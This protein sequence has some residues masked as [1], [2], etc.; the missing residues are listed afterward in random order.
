[1]TEPD[2]SQVTAARAGNALWPGLCAF[3]GVTFL[4]YLGVEALS[5]VV[6]VNVALFGQLAAAAALAAVGV[7]ALMRAR[8]F[9]VELET[10]NGRRRLSGLSKAEQRAAM[11]RYAPS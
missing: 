6:P 2:P 7:T 3:A 9:Y 1:M 10:E 5:G 4:V 8:Y 11:A